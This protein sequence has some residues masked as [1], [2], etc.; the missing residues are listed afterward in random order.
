M[1][2]LA[3]LRSWWKVPCI[4]HFCSLFRGVLFEQSDLDIE[5][6]EE[7]LLQ[8]VSPGDS[9]VILDLLCSLLE[10]IYGRE[11]LTV[12]DYDKYLKDIFRYQHAMGNIKRNP[13]VDKTYFELSLRQ[14]VDVLHDLCDFRLE[15]EDV[16]EVL[17][18]HDGDNMRVEPLGHDVNGI[19]YW[20]FYGTRLYQEDPPPK[21]PEEEKSKAKIVP[22]RWHMVCCTLEDWQNLAEFF[23]ESEVKCEKA[24]Y[25][26]IVE[27]FLPE[28]PNIVAERVSSILYWQ[29]Q[30]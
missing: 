12:V 22:S 17:K 5:D 3:E 2:P 24:L 8:A 30:S 20:Y 21:E 29:I 10:G 28:I 9:P 25:R 7:A 23:K 27:D 6:L 26:T 14:K 4:A 16:M 1:D 19:T 15:S 18:G 13:L 11:K